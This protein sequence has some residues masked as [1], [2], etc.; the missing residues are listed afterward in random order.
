MR[1]R[2]INSFDDMLSSFD[3][4]LLLIIMM[5]IMN[6]GLMTQMI[7][8]EGICLTACEEVSFFLSSVLYTC[9]R[10]SSRPSSTLFLRIHLNHV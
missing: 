9:I 8:G 1:I 4:P 6:E 7:V 3:L 2:R 10:S 5:M